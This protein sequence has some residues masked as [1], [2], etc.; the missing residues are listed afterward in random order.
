MVYH[1][2]DR[3]DSLCVA[4][5][6][7]VTCTV[8]VPKMLNKKRANRVDSLMTGPLILGKLVTHVA[9]VGILGALH[10]RS[11]ADTACL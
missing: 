10:P 8:R 2:W 4:Q 1:L 9:R 3:K 5:C 7:I 6:N 11:P